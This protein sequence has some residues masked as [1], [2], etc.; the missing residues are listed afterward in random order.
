[1]TVARMESPKAER[2]VPM[3]AGSKEAKWAVH[4]DS[5][6]V[7]SRELQ[8]VEKRV[9]LTAVRRAST[10]AVMTGVYSAVWRVQLM[11]D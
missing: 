3:K 10:R 1:M 2:L 6:T 7:D 4:L 9:S 8:W 11:V 5:L